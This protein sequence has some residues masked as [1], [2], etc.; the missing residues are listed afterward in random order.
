MEKLLVS[1][2]VPLL[3]SPSELSKASPLDYRLGLDL[4]S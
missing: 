4:E 2:L 1:P 3:D